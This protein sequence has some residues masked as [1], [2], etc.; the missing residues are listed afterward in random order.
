MQDHVGPFRT[1]AGLTEGLAR[2]AALRAAL[3]TTL[4]GGLGPQDPVRLD[5]L[6]L[7]N[8]LLVAEAVTHAALARKESRGAHQRED[9]P[10]QD[11]SWTLNQTIA[12]QA[13]R[14]VLATQPVA[15][16]DLPAAASTGLSSLQPSSQPSSQPSL[17]LNSPPPAIAV[18]PFA[19]GLKQ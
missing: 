7:R 10:T 11:A 8:M 15:R 13:G 5:A 18:A 14:W 9:Y 6:D 3:G 1:E 12:L 17:P 16:L 4:P 19:P 2:L